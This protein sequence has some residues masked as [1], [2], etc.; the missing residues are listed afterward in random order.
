MDKQF[1]K[2]ENARKAG[3]S[4]DKNYLA[5]YCSKRF[6][7]N[8]NYKGNPITYS[9]SNKEMKEIKDKVKGLSEQKLYMLFEIMDYTQ[10]HIKYFRYN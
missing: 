2:V 6:V 1:E 10:K 5:Y 3:I 4:P 8:L 7:S 9:K